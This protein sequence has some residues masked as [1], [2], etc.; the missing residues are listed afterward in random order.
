MRV[1][2]R[3][4]FA[5]W[6]YLAW[7]WQRSWWGVCWPFVP[8]LG[9]ETL[10]VEVAAP[11]VGVTALESSSQLFLLNT[12]KNLSCSRLLASSL[13]TPRSGGPW[14]FALF[15]AFRIFKSSSGCCWTRRPCRTAMA[16][17]QI[18]Q[19]HPTAP[20]MSGRPRNRAGVEDSASQPV[21]GQLADTGSEVRGGGWG[22]GTVSI[23]SGSRAREVCMLKWVVDLLC[24]CST[25]Q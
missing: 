18:V 5:G 8:T 1:C 7:V 19:K 20:G 25:S 6:S 23:L 13:R 10:G 9:F 11:D 22:P 15:R 4:R 21:R 2:N 24:G 16:S 17:S 3:Q 14:C 12:A